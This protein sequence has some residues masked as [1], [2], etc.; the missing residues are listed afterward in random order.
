MYEILCQAGL[1]AF[2]MFV[3]I[4]GH[5]TNAQNTSAFIC[6]CLAYFTTWLELKE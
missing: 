5:G 3:I 2:M 4:C 1:A 6:F